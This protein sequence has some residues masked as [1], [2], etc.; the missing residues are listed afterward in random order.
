[1]PSHIRG[2]ST[3]FHRSTTFC[4]RYRRNQI[5]STFTM[6][7]YCLQRAATMPPGYSSLKL[8]KLHKAWISSISHASRCMVPMPCG[9]ALVS[10]T[11]HQMKFQQSWQATAKVR[12]TWLLIS[13]KTSTLSFE[14]N[15][16]TPVRVLYME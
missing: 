16:L 6:S 1:M 9:R 13:Y 3:P 2:Y 14:D 5:A 7:R 15:T 12:N 4:T 8:E 10:V 11:S